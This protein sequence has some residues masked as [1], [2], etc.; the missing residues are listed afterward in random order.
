MVRNYHIKYQKINVDRARRRVGGS[1]ISCYIYSQLEYITNDQPRNNFNKDSS[2]H[3]LV[4]CKIADHDSS[5]ANG[6]DQKTKTHK[7]EKSQK[8]TTGN[9]ENNKALT[10]GRCRQLDN[11]PSPI[12]ISDVAR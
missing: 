2:N 1:V 5:R 6:K 10:K 9:D 4:K 3:R 7:N 12:P 8:R 11:T